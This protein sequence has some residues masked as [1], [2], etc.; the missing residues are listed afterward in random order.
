MPGNS[1]IKELREQVTGLNKKTVALIRKHG[2]GVIPLLAQHGDD[3]L[4]LLQRYGPDVINVYTAAN[5]LLLD[6]DVLEYAMQQGPEAV[7]ALSKWDPVE[8][9]L[10]GPELALRAEKDGKVLTAIEKLTSMGPVNPDKLTA[11]QQALIE[12]IAANSTQNAENAQVV[13]GKWVDI[14]SGFVETAKNTG[15]THYNPHPAVWGMLGRLGKEGQEEV[16]WLINKQV[17]QNG[18]ANNKPFEYTLNG[19][20]AKNIDDEANA[21]EAIFADATDEE[22]KNILGSDYL[23][24]RMKE[25]QELKKAGYTYS[26]DE[27]KSSFVLTSPEKGKEK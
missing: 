22:I 1:V 2:D 6:D 3:A 11:E 21:I 14:D 23:P 25:L 10:Y 5:L 18:I 15:S 8:L 19:V 12:A 16:A 4:R 24:V 17:I 9:R 20:P 13:L 7:R 27:A 26:Y